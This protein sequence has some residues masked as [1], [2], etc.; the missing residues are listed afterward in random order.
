MQNFD[1]VLDLFVEAFQ[2]KISKD[3]KSGRSYRSM[4]AAKVQDIGRGDDRLKVAAQVMKKFIVESNKKVIVEP[5]DV[6]AIAKARAE[7]WEQYHASR[8]RAV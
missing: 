3:R 5:F 8:G 6:V 7:S 2:L 1:T 4:K